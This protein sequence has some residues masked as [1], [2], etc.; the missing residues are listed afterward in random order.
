MNLTVNGMNIE[1]KSVELNL[2]KDD[3]EGFNGLVETLKD[4]KLEFTAEYTITPGGK[5]F[6]DK[7]RN[8]SKLKKEWLKEKIEKY[9]SVIKIWK[10]DKY[11]WVTRK[12]Q[13]SEINKLKRTLKNLK[14]RLG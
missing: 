6:F 10:S 14:A 3:C 12:K 9:A 5:L 4:A 11:D 13:I 7:K 2:K 8:L 1:I